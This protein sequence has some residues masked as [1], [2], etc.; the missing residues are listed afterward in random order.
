MNQQNKLYRKGT[1]I[2]NSEIRISRAAAEEND[3]DSKIRYLIQFNDT[4]ITLTATESQVNSLKFYKFNSGYLKM[5]LRIEDI[6]DHLR[7]TLAIRKNAVLEIKE[8]KLEDI[9]T[10]QIIIKF[11]V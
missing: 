11:N 9:T 5:V 3:I 6:P 2:E 8:T 10:K 7:Q 4:D 1:V